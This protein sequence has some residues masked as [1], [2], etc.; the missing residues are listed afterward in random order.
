MF[1]LGTVLLPGAHLALHVFEPRYR[2]LVRVCLEGTPEFGVALIERGT[3][4]GGGDS[5]FDVGCVARIVDAV[6]FED[7]R[8]A[9]GTVGVRRIRIERWLPDAPYPRAEV[10]DWDDPPPRSTAVD[11]RRDLVARL[12]Q[13]LALA[14][15]MGAQVADATV[16]VDDDPV[17][18]GYQVAALAPLGPMDRLAALAAPSPDERTRLLTRLLDDT[19]VVLAARVAG[20]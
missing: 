16:D 3:E 5:R 12:R 20:G 11:D 8:W 10:S 2:E 4:V 18:A 15:E 1:P 7:G 17:R 14:A 19:A 13:V 9:L 6:P